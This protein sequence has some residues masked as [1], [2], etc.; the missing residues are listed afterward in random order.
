MRD[1]NLHDHEARISVVEKAIEKIGQN[2][3]E[4]IRFHV[5]LPATLE[6]QTKV[7][8][9]RARKMAVKAVADHKIECRKGVTREFPAVELRGNWGDLAKKIL[10]G[11]AIVGALLGGAYSEIHST[12]AKL[13]DQ[14]GQPPVATAPK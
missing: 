3:D 14:G 5:N 12:R 8:L 7:T 1:P 11:L 9:R 6:A 13:A 10:A 4:L 2:T